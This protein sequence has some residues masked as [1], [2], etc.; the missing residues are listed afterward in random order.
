MKKI[1]S[2]SPGVFFFDGTYKITETH[3]ETL[4]IL[5]TIIPDNSTVP[6]FCFTA[7]N[8]TSEV[9]DAFFSKFIESND[10]E[11]VRLIVTDKAFHERN[12]LKRHFILANLRLCYFHIRQTFRLKIAEF[13]KIENSR[14]QL[15]KKKEK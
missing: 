7:K 9:L 10:P 2:C 8:E 6:V 13:I 4:F 1:Y 5:S 12:A 3:T 14:K 11:V 15:N